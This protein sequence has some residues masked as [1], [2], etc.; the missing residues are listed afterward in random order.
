MERYFDEI[1][2]WGTVV[3]RSTNYIMVKWDRDPWSYDQIPI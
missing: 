3:L 2:G 1:N